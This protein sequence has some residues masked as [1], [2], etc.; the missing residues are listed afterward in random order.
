MRGPRPT[1]QPHPG[2][3]R[4]CP[5][6]LGESYVVGREGDRASAALC[7]CVGPCPTCRGTGFVARGTGFRAPRVRC[8][9][10][11]VDRRIQRFNRARIPARQAP[12]TIGNF[13]PSDARVTPSYMRVR[14]YLSAFDPREENRGLVFYGEVGRGKTHLMVA[15]L[16]ELIFTW[17]L[18][19]RFIEFSHLIADL[20]SA[21]DKGSGSSRLLDPLGRVD[22]LAVDEL[23]KGLGTDFET[24]VVDE[25]VSRRYDARGVLLASTNYRPGKAQG[26]VTSNLT[27]AGRAGASAPTLPD[28][29]GPRVFSRLAE[30][31]D[32][33]PLVGPDY[34]LRDK[35]H[36]SE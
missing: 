11:Q 22:V 30:M 14:K 17:G 6:C 10:A 19:A 15:V 24:H 8:G 13:D 34:R 7:A 23:G 1:F 32:F 36:W 26:Q 27:L 25:V 16:R 5:R 31:C 12:C 35:P 18:T 9:C 3:E 29:V 28:R 21:F 20:K 4:A 2:V 33:V